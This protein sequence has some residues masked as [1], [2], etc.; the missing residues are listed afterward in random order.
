MTR[1][2]AGESHRGSGPPVRAAASGLRDPVIRR[3]L[4]LLA[5]T[6][7]KYPRW[8]AF[9]IAS[10][11]VW[12]TFVVLVPYLT[13]VVIDRSISAGDESLLF[14]LVMAL[15]GAGLLRALGIA[16]RRYFAFALSFRAET[17]LRNRMFEHTQRLAFRFH[18]EVPAGELMARSSTDLRQVRLVF[19]MLP[20]TIANIG[21]FV[22]IGVVMVLLD[23]LLGM[24]SSLSI[25]VLLYLANRY[26]TKT[27]RISTDIQQR[28]ADL[29]TVVEEAVAGVRV[30]KAYG[31]EEREVQRLG[32]VVD[33]IYRSTMVLL[34]YSSSYVPLFGLVPTLSTILIL[35]IGG[36]RV[37]EGVMTLGEFVAFTQYMQVLVFPLR[38]TG[39]FFAQLPRASAAAVRVTDL[40][41]TD[42][43]IEDPARPLSVPPGPGE[44]RL[45][46]VSFAYP[47]G[48]PVLEDVDLSIPGG[49]SVALVGATGSGKS[50]L[51]YLIPRFYDVSGGAILLDGSDVRS[52]RLEELR[53]EV[54]IVFQDA[55][56]FSASVAENIA[57]GSPGATLEQ[58]RLAARL[59][60]AHDFIADLPDEYDTLVGE[61]GFSLS[62]GQRQRIALARAVLRD[63]RVLILDDATSSVDAVTE[64][65]IRSS[66]EKVMEGRTTVIIAHRP[67][68]LRLADQVVFIDRGRV[69]GYGKHVDLLAESPRYAEVLAEQGI[70]AGVSS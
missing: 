48:P 7:L 69:A 26:A 12:M 41:A 62:G 56:L 35:W 22:V 60:R 70:E 64:Q 46:H 30:V 6:A 16:G 11:L 50:T 28:L 15:V 17:D 68:T 58:I 9:S 65:E 29:S 14:A 52:L 67:A 20:I 45:S 34:R 13:K 47:G 39:W 40:L 36:L 2:K 63:P 27:L 31:Q 55:F 18:D 66:L 38:I 5:T 25:P 44:I 23:P 49:S 42:P 37:I 43:E 4:G 51:A 54:S 19:A 24:I 3:G 59:T 1:R 21:L 33:R 53:S 32:G 10:A 61:R 8:A 57:F